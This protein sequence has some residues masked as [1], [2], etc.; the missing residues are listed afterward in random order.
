LTAQNKMKIFLLLIL[1]TLLGLSFGEDPKCFF[2]A[3]DEDDIEKDCA[4]NPTKNPPTEKSCIRSDACVTQ[5]GN[6]ITELGTKRVEYRQCGN[7][8]KNLDA[9]NCKEET[10]NT[11]DVKT[12]FCQ[13][14]LC[15]K[16]GS[17]LPVWVWIVIALVVV[18]IIGAV[19]A[20]IIWKLKSRKGEISKEVP[21]AESVPLKLQEA[22]KTDGEGQ[23]SQDDVP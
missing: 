16:P 22:T 4:V 15:N 14:E 13:G 2:C 21:E 11:L 12:C 23:K 9:N 5:V 1:F 17:G 7:M 6:S 8:E 3:F 18:L 19:V 20:L 10:L